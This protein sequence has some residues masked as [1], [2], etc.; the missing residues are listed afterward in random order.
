VFSGRFDAVS[1]GTFGSLD[2]R[3]LSTALF[4]AVDGRPGTAVVAGALRVFAG[5]IV[6][7]AVVGV[8]LF[9]AQLLTLVPFVGATGF[10]PPVI[11]AVLVGAIALLFWAMAEALV[12]LG[13][14]ADALE[15]IE[16]AIRNRPS[17]AAAPAADPRNTKTAGV[18]DVPG[19]Q[20]YQRP[21]QRVVKWTASVTNGPAL[22]AKPVCEIAAGEPVTAIGEVADFAFVESPGGNGWLPKDSLAERPAA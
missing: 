17:L 4:S 19:F 5:L 6:V 13:E 21:M 10:V 2:P 8:A 20:R 11:F 14:H 7:G 9:R 3:P 16:R 15:R 18:G 22:L 12:M 1:P